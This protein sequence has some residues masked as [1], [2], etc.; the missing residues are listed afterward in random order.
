MNNC[1]FLLNQP[2]PY[3]TNTSYKSIYALDLSSNVDTSEVTSMENMFSE[4]SSLAFL[5]LRGFNTQNV[6][7][8]SY[9]FCNSLLL[10][11]LN[12]SSFNTQKVNNMN[13]MFSGC[14]FLTHLTLGP[15][16]GI[17]TAITSL[18]LSYCQLTYDSCFDVFRK[19]ADK[20][21]TATPSA[22]LTLNS[23]TKARMSSTEIAMA[24]AKGWT[25]S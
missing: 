9:M 5:D 20:T 24:T 16:W 10:T 14:A 22:T 12:L 17:N 8:M 11:Y 18:D 7:N 15:D 25:V 4:W 21:K 3:E 13:Y 19:L 23:T 1:V 6:L 2:I